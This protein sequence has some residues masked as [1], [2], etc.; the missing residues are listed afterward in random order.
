MP[1]TPTAVVSST[2]IYLA[3]SVP[4]G[5]VVE[6]YEVVWERVTTRKCPDEDIGSTLITDGSTSY[7]IV[8]LE[9]GSSYSIV[10][11]ASNAAGSAVSESVTGSTGESGEG[12]I[13][14]V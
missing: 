5:S 10:V 1:G 8:G 6:S 4:S 11:T 13:R 2:S 14:I 12:L 9:E 7:N 3:W